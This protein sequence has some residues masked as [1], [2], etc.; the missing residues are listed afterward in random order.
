MNAEQIA[1]RLHA[2]HSRGG[3][4]AR[5]PAHPD[6]SPSLSIRE[7]NDGRTLVY[8]HAGCTTEAVCEAIGIK[9]ADLFSKPGQAQ[10]KPR[11]VR[12]AERAISDLR[13]RLTPRERLLPVTVVYCGPDNLDAGMARALALSVEGDEVVQCILED[14]AC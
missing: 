11:A 14:H 1:E 2:R 7:G 4:I 13:S 9:V 3:W 6:R 5:C 8:C 10:S 12:E